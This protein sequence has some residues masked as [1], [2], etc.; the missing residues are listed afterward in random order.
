MPP[1]FLQGS[2]NASLIYPFLPVSVTQS[3]SL[4]LKH[5]LAVE[6]QKDAPLSKSI[7]ACLQQPGP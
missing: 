2:G 3:E 6:E 1:G 7:S 5:D 4:Q